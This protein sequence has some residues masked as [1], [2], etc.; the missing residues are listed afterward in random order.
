MTRYF[1]VT[2]QKEILNRIRR[3]AA[4]EEYENR[5]SNRFRR[6]FPPDDK[7]RRE[8]YA[9]LLN[10]SFKTF[11][12]GRS[13]S[14]QKE[15]EEQYSQRYRE[16]DILDMLAECEARSA[17][18]EGDDLHRVRTLP[19]GGKTFLAP[20]IMSNG[21]SKCWTLSISLDKQYKFSL[22]LLIRFTRNLL[23]L[24]G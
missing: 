2:S 23:T 10:E 19:F 8:R 6:I 1:Y 22:I 21:V 4:R 16:E 14:L 9:A 13:S 12:A 5:H 17:G 18:D 7:F 24:I 3:E 11:L 15:I 20:L